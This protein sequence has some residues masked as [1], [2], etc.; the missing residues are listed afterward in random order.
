MGEQA[1]YLDRPDGERIAYLETDGPRDRPTMVW[2]G[3]FKSDMR[4]T[5]AEHLAAWAEDR[6]VRYIRFDYLGHGESSGRFVDGTV[7]RWREDSLAILDAIVDGACILIGSSMGG[8]MALLAALARP[9]RV[10]AMQ[11]I[12]PAPDFTEALLWPGLSDDAK[13][14]I[15]TEGVWA[16]PSAYGDG[17]YE[18]SRNLI[19]DGRS[20]LLLDRPI[21]FSG[22]VS[23]LHGMDDPD[24][25][26]RH[27]LHLVEAF[28]AEDVALTLVKGGD[29]RLSTERDLARL[30]ASLDALL[31]KTA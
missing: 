21:P 30:H 15:E 22:P 4:G 28:D 9:D 27:A 31:A 19:E 16:A 23:I 5:K 10:K 1:L 25:P 13:R 20:H 11:L 3:G 24:V 17:P 2:L 12:A 7:S 18:I 6:S 29:H 26:W 14:A 8:W